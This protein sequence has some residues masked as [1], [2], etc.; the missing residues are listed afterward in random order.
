MWFRTSQYN[1][2]QG[3]EN[4][5]PHGRLRM[6]IPCLHQM[7]PQQSYWHLVCVVMLLRDKGGYLN[8]CVYIYIYLYIILHT[9]IYIYIYIQIYT[10]LKSC[11]IHSCLHWCSCRVT[12]GL[13][14][15][16]ILW[17]DSCG[18]N[19]KRT[20]DWSKLEEKYAK[21]IAADGRYLGLVDIAM[22][23]RKF[24]KTPVLLYYDQDFQGQNPLR[25]LRNIFNGMLGFDE[26]PMPPMDSPDTWV[27]G[28]CRSDFSR[29][30]FLSLNH[31]I[32]IWTRQ[33]M[34]SVWEDV[35]P[36]TQGKLEKRIASTFK[37]L[38]LESEDSDSGGEARKASLREQ[39][40]SLL[41]KKNS[42]TSWLTWICFP[43]TYLGMAIVCCGRFLPSKPVL[44]CEHSCPTSRKSLLYVRMLGSCAVGVLNGSASHFNTAKER[45]KTERNTSY[46]FLCHSILL[47][48]SWLM[49]MHFWSPE[50]HRSWFEGKS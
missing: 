16:G 23:G 50:S 15:A 5:V 24:N 7:R 39:L 21:H 31:Y 9:R 48:P 40:E 30:G 46:V 25:L 33:Q 45:K 10:H 8:Q 2:I 28:V 26:E 41:Q 18:S 49:S 37:K 19:I 44:S 29:E 17:H 34:G 38:E 13:G 6:H 43:R 1:S 36:Q 14:E 47:D 4:Q 11:W 35:V 42:L 22:L 20:V 3:W 32:P 27:I 12:E